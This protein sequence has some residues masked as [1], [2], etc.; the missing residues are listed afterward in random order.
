MADRSHEGT[1]IVSG[2][3]QANGDRKGFPWCNGFT[4]Q[5]PGTGI[6]QIAFLHKLAIDKELS[7]GCP[8]GSS[9]AQS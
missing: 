8:P 9:D 2:A 1:I 6:K 4:Q 5:Q 3:D 7:I